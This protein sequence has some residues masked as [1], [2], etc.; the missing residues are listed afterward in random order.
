MLLPRARQ[1][2]DL[3]FDGIARGKLRADFSRSPLEILGGP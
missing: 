3:D 1:T 2:G